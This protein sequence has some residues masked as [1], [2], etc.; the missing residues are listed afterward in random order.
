MT[1]TEADAS[2]KTVPD[3]RRAV[4][5]R[6]VRTGS[7]LRKRSHGVSRSAAMPTPNWKNA[8][9]RK[10]KPANDAS[11]IVAFLSSRETTK[12]RKNR[13][14]KRERRNAESR[15]AEELDGHRLRV[16]KGQPHASLPVRVRKASSSEPPCALASWL[17][18]PSATM[19]PRA[20][21]A[22]RVATAS[23]SSR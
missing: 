3:S 19:R 11:S 1:T 18:D 14:G 8:T 7:V 10:A 22:T 12:R 9:A 5:R 15:V 2:P 21:S 16:E 17:G 4:K 23:A 6:L 20:S 13:P